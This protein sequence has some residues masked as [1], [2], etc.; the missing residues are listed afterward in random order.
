MIAGIGI[1][2]TGNVGIYNSSYIPQSYPQINTGEGNDTITGIG[3]FIN[4]GSI[5]TGNGNDSIFSYEGL[6]NYNYFTASTIDTGN[7]NDTITSF[8]TIFNNGEI[9]TGNGN[10]S[11][12]VYG[13]VGADFEGGGNVFLGDG[14]DYLKGFGSGNFYGGTGK[15]RLELTAGIYTVG[16]SERSTSPRIALS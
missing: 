6:S 10:D 5:N 1:T 15:D 8:G 9:N 14:K 7:G 2:G 12:I 3:D 11:I 16:I 13:G 4:E